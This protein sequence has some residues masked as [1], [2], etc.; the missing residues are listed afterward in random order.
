MLQSWEHAPDPGTLLSYQGGHFILSSL[1]VFAQEATG[2]CF[3]SGFDRLPVV[4]FLSPSSLGG[5][6]YRN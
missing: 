4:W 3:A 1:P 2:V 5:F 6:N